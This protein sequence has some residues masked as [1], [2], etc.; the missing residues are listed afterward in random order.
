LNLNNE[1]VHRM[2]LKLSVIQYAVLASKVSFS[3]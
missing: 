2:Y 1:K 3:Q